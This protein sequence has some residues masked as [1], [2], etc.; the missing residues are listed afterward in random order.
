M[1]SPGYLMVLFVL[2][3]VRSTEATSQV[4]DTIRGS[5]ALDSRVLPYTLYQCGTSANNTVKSPIILFLHGAGERGNDNRLQ[6][7]RVVPRILQTLQEMK[8]EH[9]CL[10]APQCPENEKWV[11]KEWNAA[12]HTMD[13][14]PGWPLAFAV[15]VL[16]SLL[17]SDKLDTNRIY[18]TGLSMGGFGTW[19]LVQRYP[20][21]F[22][23]AIPICGGGDLAQAPKLKNVPIW[24]FHGKKDRLVKVSRTIDMVNAIKKVKGKARMTLF[25]DQGHIC[26]EPVYGNAG[27]IQWM[28]EQHKDEK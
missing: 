5:F 27:V 26:W 23:A 7:S 1:R 25:E 21:K 8:V 2:L 16:D 20:W 28:L 24:A 9:W 11:N 19:E 14:S 15:Q 10:L 3:L 18:V 17:V 22:S 12:S 4:V 6:V 13:S